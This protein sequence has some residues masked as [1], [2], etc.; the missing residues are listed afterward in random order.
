[1]ARRIIAFI[2]DLTVG[3]GPSPTRR[4]PRCGGSASARSWI[5]AISA[6]GLDRKLAQEAILR[7]T[8]RALFIQSESSEHF[9]PETPAANEIAETLNQRR[10]LSLDLCYGHDLPASSYAFL[11]DNGLS[12]E[13]YERLRDDGVPIAGFTWYS[14]VD[15]VDRDSLLRQDAGNVNPFGLFDLDRRIRPVGEAYARLVAQWRE[16]LPGESLSIE[17]EDP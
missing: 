16:I 13:R 14:L 3:I 15:Q 4:S 5:C 11:L 2:S 7:V 6:S 1:M 9:H 8:P 17:I 12:R 10:F